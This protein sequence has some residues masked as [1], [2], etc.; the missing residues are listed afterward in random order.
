MTLIFLCCGLGI[1]FLWVLREVLQHFR[2]DR[3][4]FGNFGQGA[5]GIAAV[6]AIFG[7]MGVYFAGREYQAKIDLH[8]PTISV[9]RT[10]DTGPSQVVLLGVSVP[11]ENR[12]SHG[13]QIKCAA[14]DLIGLSAGA[15]PSTTYI[16]DLDGT[17]LLSPPRQTDA[18][19][20]CT[21]EFEPERERLE[22]LERQAGGS[23]YRPFNPGRRSRPAL[24]G[25]RYSDFY[26]EPGETLTRNW[27]QWVPCSFVAV[28]VIFKVPKPHSTADLET[29]VVVPIADACKSS[30]QSAEPGPERG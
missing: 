5:A 19:K 17:S 14:I 15:L 30:S 2:I 24:S 13:L 1:M 21:K 25:A 12:S 27:E 11:V 26:L 28:R 6:V 22:G 7:G 4:A 18:W 10:A 8:S 29:K 20:R 9:I 3:A 16:E 23:D